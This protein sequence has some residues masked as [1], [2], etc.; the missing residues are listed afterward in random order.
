MTIT[1]SYGSRGGTSRAPTRRRIGARSEDADHV[2]AAAISLLSCS[3]E[4]FDQSWRQRSFG[5]PVKAR[6]QACLLQERPR[7]W[8]GDGLRYF[9]FLGMA[10]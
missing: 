7:T 4:S 2:S 8:G 9:G 3:S 10:R 1:S 6:F 5:K